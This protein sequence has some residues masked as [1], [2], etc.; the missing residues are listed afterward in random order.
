MK[1]KLKRVLK[2][3]FLAVSAAILMIASV[4]LFPQALFAKKIA[5]KKFTVYSSDNVDN[6][7]KIVLDD[8]LALVQE[9]ELYDSNYTYNI[10]LCNG[11]FY[12]K[13][14]DK[15]LGVGRTARATLRNVIIKVSIDPKQNLAFPAFHKPC[16]E[17]L[18]Q[19]IAHEMIHC[20]QAN[21]YGLF[22]FNP[23]RHPE[24]WKLEG[25]PEYIS[26]RRDVS[27]E[28]YDLRSDIN[29][30]VKVESEAKDIWIS[31][32]DGG[33]E[34]PDYYY[35]GRLMME[36]LIDIKHLSYDQVLNDTT[37][38]NSVYQEMINWKGSTK[39][40]KIDKAGY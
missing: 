39:R 14:D 6:H 22:K 25:Y 27:N 19:V 5:Y 28:G 15:L 11:S 32:E 17:N 12:N 8:A 4:L 26:K 33:C 3:A 2:I 1:K 37:S 16:E 7:I 30:Y 36:Y 10:I 40:G 24:F 18:T 35:R 9:S 38:E 34:V 20:L 21:K 23:F 13:I 29:R 31:S